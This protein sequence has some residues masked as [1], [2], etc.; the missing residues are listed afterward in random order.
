MLILLIGNPDIHPSLS[1]QLKIMILDK[2]QIDFFSN[3]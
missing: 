1:L 3:I 2:E